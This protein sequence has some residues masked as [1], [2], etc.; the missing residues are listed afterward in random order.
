MLI[1]KEGDNNI[2]VKFYHPLCQPDEIENTTGICVE[3]ERRCS[4]VTVKLNGEVVGQGMSVC[5]PNDNFCKSIG[6]KKALAYSL[7]A[8]TRQARI[9]VWDA[10]KE[11]CRL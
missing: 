4:L 10:Y 2:E 1:V 3:E 5:H 8:L 7:Y 6:R 9:A 11:S